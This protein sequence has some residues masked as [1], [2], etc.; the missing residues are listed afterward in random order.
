LKRRTVRRQPEVSEEYIACT[1]RSIVKKQ[2]KQ[3]NLSLPPASAGFLLRLFFKPEDGGDIFFRNLGQ[4]PYF[5]YFFQP[6]LGSTLKLGS[7]ATCP[8]DTK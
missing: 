2:H 6:Q 5:R 4:S 7:S 1:F 3:M 8:S